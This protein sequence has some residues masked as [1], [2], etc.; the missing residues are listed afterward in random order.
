MREIAR[1]T[2][3]LP[4][5]L[6]RMLENALDW[7]HLPHLHRTTFSDG[8]LLDHAGDFWEARLRLAGY[9][10]LSQVVRLTLDPDAGVWISEVRSGVSKGMSI[11]TTAVA[12]GP[13]TLTVDVRFRVPGRRP[14]NPWL[15]RQMVATYRR[16]YDEDEGMMVERQRQLDTARP[17]D[18]APVRLGTEAEIGAPGFTFAKG[19]RVFSVGRVD[20]HWIAWSALCPHWLGPLAGQDVIDGC[21]ECPWHGY[22]F[23]VRSGRCIDRPLKLMPAPTLRRDAEG[24]F[25]A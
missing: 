2:R 20:G 23:D 12:S 1:Y 5:S 15:G 6:E 18:D 21:V 3:E 4:V 9:G 19:G 25:W 22:R 11:H 14:W 7:E 13:R 16:L 24:V 10:G 17:R 8:T